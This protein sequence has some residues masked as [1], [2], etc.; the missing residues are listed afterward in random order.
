VQSRSG[1]NKIAE[2]SSEFRSIEAV[3]QHSVDLMVASNRQRILLQLEEALGK[4]LTTSETT[5]EQSTGVFVDS[6]P[7]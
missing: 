1:P 5:Y 2:D 3:Y 7:D 4:D 6:L